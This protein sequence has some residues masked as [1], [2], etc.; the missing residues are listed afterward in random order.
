MKPAARVV[1]VL[2]AVATVACAVVACWV[3]GGDAGRLAGTATILGFTALVTAL[4]GW[5]P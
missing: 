2:L 5:Q 3:T 1:T 4:V